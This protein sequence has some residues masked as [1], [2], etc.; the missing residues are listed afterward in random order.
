LAA[1]IYQLNFKALVEQNHLFLVVTTRH[2]TDFFPGRIDPIIKE[3]QRMSDDE[4]D[5]ENDEE[6][7]FL[8]RYRIR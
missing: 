7:M 4:N 5:A 2:L 1:V 8:E 3:L 6:L